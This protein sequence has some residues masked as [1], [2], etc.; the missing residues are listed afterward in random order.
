MWSSAD[1]RRR[2]RRVLM[3]LLAEDLLALPQ[4]QSC[5]REHLPVSSVSPPGVRRSPAGGVRWIETVRRF[6]WPPTAYVTRERSRTSDA[7]SCSVLAW[8]SCRLSDA[9]ADVA[10]LSPALHEQ[11]GA[12]IAALHDVTGQLS[13]SDYGRAPDRSELLASVNGAPN[14]RMWDERGFIRLRA[15]PLMP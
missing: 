10:T 8:I 2:S 1:V 12:P 9:L 4:D 15:T 6:G 7:L 14:R 3:G 5:W 13:A 11:L